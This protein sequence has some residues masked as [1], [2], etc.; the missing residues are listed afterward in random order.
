MRLKRETVCLDT[1]QIAE[2]FDVD[3]TGAV[4]HIRNI[5]KSGKLKRDSTCAKIAQV[6]KDGKV[7]TMDFYNLDMII[8][9]C[10]PVNSKRIAR[11]DYFSAGEGAEKTAERSGKRD[12]KPSGRLCQNIARVGT[13]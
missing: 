8:S 11:K 4:R 9:V 7:R 1:H 5:Y 3:R 10:Y 6:A 2:L 13:V 12:F